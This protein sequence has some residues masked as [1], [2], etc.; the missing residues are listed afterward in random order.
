MALCGGWSLPFTLCLLG[1]VEGCH[2]QASVGGATQG[3][4][5]ECHAQASVGGAPHK[6]SVGWAPRK[7]SVGGRHTQASVGGSTHRLL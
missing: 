7:A 5:E 4:C 1:S 3:F 6:A 2:A